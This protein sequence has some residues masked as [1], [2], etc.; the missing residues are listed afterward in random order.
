MKYAEYQF[1]CTF[2][3]Q[4][5]L[6]QHKGSGLRGLFGHCLKKVAC[7]QRRSECE[8]CLLSTSCVYFQIFES[9]K[10]PVKAKAGNNVKPHP[11]VLVPPMD[12]DRREYAPGDRFDMTFKLFGNAIEWLPY[13]VFCVEQMGKT[14]LGARSR[15]GWG[16]FHLDS[17]VCGAEEIYSGGTRMLEQS[18]CWKILDVQKIEPVT[19][20]SVEVFFTMPLRLKSGNRLTDS[21]DFQTLIRA[22]CRRIAVLEEAFGSGEPALDYRGL[23]RMAGEVD[24]V[25]SDTRWERVYR[26]S[27]RQKTKMNI[28]GIVGKMKYRGDITP[29]WPLLKYCESVHI[30]K[31]TAFGNGRIAVVAG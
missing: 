28:G 10:M 23:V 30:G 8:T 20:N 3:T 22:C 27:S 9:P 25:E 2:E 6:S 14:G 17:V 11:F 4:A 18:G 24:A 13:I 31:Q 16:R 12:T 1:R 5:L 21:V 26:Y 29:F 19:V 7:A 15:H